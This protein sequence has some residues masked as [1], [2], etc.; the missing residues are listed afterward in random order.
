MRLENWFTASF[1]PEVRPEG[2]TFKTH[3]ECTFMHA[4]MAFFSFFFFPLHSVVCVTNVKLSRNGPIRY[5][6]GFPF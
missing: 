1:S 2:V 4:W 6:I 3:V 5:C